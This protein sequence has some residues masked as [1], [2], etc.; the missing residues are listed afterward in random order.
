M[1]TSSV[2]IPFSLLTGAPLEDAVRDVLGA[3]RAHLCE[4]LADGSWTV[5]LSPE[6]GAICMDGLG[7]GRVRLRFGRSARLEET[8]DFSIDEESRMLLLKVP[9]AH[10]NGT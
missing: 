5:E 6:P 2:H 3:H 8:F 10:F 7:R 9:E 4:R 1:T